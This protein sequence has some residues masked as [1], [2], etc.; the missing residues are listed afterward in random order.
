MTIKMAETCFGY[1]V[2]VFDAYKRCVLIPAV[3]QE[4]EEMEMDW[5]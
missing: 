1:G 3:E 4:K 2:I 5:S